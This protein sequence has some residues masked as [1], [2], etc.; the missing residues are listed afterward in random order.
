MVKVSHSSRT[1]RT[2]TY[3]KEKQDVGENRATKFVSFRTKKQRNR[4]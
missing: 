3:Q 4:K 1:T 2:G